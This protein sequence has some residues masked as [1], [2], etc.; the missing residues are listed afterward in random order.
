MKLLVG[1]GLVVTFG[2]P[3][4]VVADGGVLIDGARIAAVAPYADL[5][6]PHADAERLDAGGRMILPGLV[7][8]HMHFYS[9]FA[10]GIPMTGE[11][12]RTFP[13]IL[14]RLWWRLDKALRPRD[15]YLS[16]AIPILQGLR[17]GVTTYLDHH[18]SPH[19]RD[20]TPAGSLDELAQAVLDLGV[21]A[22]LCY[23]VSDRDGEV[24]ALAGLQEN[25]KFIERV[26]RERPARLG[27]VFGL[28]AQFTVNDQT[29]EEARRIGEYMRTG[30]HV[31]CA[32][33]VSDVSDAKRRGFA[34]AVERL[35]A[36]GI[37]GHRSILA[38]CVHVSDVEVDLL[39]STGTAVTHQPQSNMNNAVGAAE[40]VRLRERGVLLGIGT[41]GMTPNVMEDVRVASWLARHRAGDPRRGWAEPVWAL[42]VGN[43]RIASRYFDRPVGVLAPDAAADVAVMD[44]LPPTPVDDAHVGGHLVFGAG[45]ARAWHVVCDGK[46]LLRDG[47]LAPDLEALEP[48]LAEEAR[49][50]AAA[51]WERW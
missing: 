17:F 47:R 35:H 43:P 41:D 6:A 49:S 16:A 13:E 20:G 5:V 18:A 50:R 51:L 14:E 12:A 39:A 36:H 31:H 23:E 38:H 44:V 37:L 24:V 48:A 28:H 33:D 2:E 32:E 40:I 22:C 19:Y 46:V 11:P 45:S 9:T 29:L 15:V 10:R 1:P 4:R 42:T 21:R 34:G 25:E 7:N 27:A 26:K 30:F 8:A 3:C